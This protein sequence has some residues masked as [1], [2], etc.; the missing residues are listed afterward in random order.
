[1]LGELTIGTYYYLKDLL[2]ETCVFLILKMIV[3][4]KTECCSFMLSKQSLL[5]FQV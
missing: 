2:V 5:K 3:Q 1:M 4:K